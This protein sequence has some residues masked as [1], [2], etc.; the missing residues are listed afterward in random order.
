MFLLVMPH[1]MEIPTWTGVGGSGW[2]ISCNI[3]QSMVPS[4]MFINS[5]AVSSSAAEDR[6]MHI[7]LMRLRMAPLDVVLCSWPR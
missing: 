3:V 7:I 2:P 5:P 4:F 6:T 1:A